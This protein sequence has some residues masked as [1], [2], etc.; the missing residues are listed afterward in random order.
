MHHQQKP[1]KGGCFQ[2]RDFW[3]PIFWRKGSHETAFVNISVC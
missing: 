2:L 1:L 3:I